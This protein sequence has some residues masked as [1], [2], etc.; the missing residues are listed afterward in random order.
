[1]GAASARRLNSLDAL[2]AEAMRIV[3]AV[4]EALGLELR[5]A[6]VQEW[7]DDGRL[8]APPDGSRNRLQIPVLLHALR[9]VAFD[10][11]FGG[12][13]R[14]EER[15]RA[16]ERVVSLRDAYGQWDPRS[17]RPEPWAAWNTRVRAGE[18]VRVFPLSNWTELDVWSYILREGIALP[19]LYRAH[20]RAV[21][22]RDGLLLAVH[23]LN[24]LRPGERAE[25]ARV[26]FRTLGDLPTTGAMRSDAR[27]VRD[28]IAENLSASQSER[29]VG[30]GDDRAS[31][32]A[33]E[34]RKRE[35][36]F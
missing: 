24:P 10:T 31:A 4:V 17:Q 12:A 21:V 2:E 30:R 28:V 34:D 36:Y 29:G 18:H 14:D 19:S 23:T 15:A 16:K 27:T 33:M 11:A 7:L 20:P 32:S 35:G 25:V 3:R 26:R 9:D 22:E 8:V 1:M 5:V 13:R 6:R